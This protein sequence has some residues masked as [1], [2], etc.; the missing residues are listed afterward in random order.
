MLTAQIA[1]NGFRR[2][3]QEALEQARKARRILEKVRGSLL[4]PTVE[5]LHGGVAGLNKAAECLQ[6]LE[7]Q[8]KLPLADPGARQALGAE[9]AGLRQELRSVEKLAAA[10]GKFF[11]GWARLANAADQSTANYTAGGQTAAVN[12]LAGRVMLDG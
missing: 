7:A 3:P 5:A 1:R 8:L 4:R 9:I 2:S 11:E 12:S 10:A 6:A